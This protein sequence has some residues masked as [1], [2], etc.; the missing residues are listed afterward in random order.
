MEAGVLFDFSGQPIHWHLPAQRTVVS[1]PDS[2]DLWDVIWENRTRVLGFAHTHPGSGR[3][4]PS[5]TDITTFIAVEKGLGRMLYWWIFSDDSAVVLWREP[6]TERFYCD[7]V[8]YDPEWAAELRRLS[9][10][11][12]G[13]P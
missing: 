4:A 5:Q 2:R 9:K 7:E 3:P 8:H 10:P 11:E 1:L 13:V 12:G 6:G